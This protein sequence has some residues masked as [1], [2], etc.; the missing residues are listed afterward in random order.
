MLGEKRVKEAEN[1]VREYL[2]EGLLKKQEFEEIVFSVLRKNAKESL[3]L[4]N[5]IH[6][7]GKSDLWAIVIS[8]Y[9][10]YYIANAV[11][12][13]IG[14]KVGERI[15]HKVTADALIVFVRKKLASSFLETYDEMREEALAGIRADSLLESFD[16]ERK[17][18]GLIQ[19]HTKELE[20]HSKAKTSINRAK[21]FMFEMEKMLRN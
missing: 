20:K 6:N 7:E 16:F 17:K 19:Y 21:E 15:S 4:A 1:N 9:S 11:L 18:R 13:R 2:K 3:D 5:F 8:Y 10:M 12:Y 14:Y